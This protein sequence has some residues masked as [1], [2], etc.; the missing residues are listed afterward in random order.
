MYYTNKAFHASTYVTVLVHIGTILQ[1]YPHKINK[2]IHT[3]P[4]Q[5][6]VAVLN[7][8]RK[9]LN[10]TLARLNIFYVIRDIGINSVT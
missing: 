4:E 2:A 7:N 6:C 9:K 3:R 8:H 5:W 1:K 10:N